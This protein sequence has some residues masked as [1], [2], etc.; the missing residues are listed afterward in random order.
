[1]LKKISQLI[2]VI[3]EKL[4][5]SF[6]FVAIVI[7]IT[8]ILFK[9]TIDTIISLLDKITIIEVLEQDNSNIKFN[10]AKKRLETYPSY[11]SIWANINIPSITV[12]A[13]IYHGDGL[14]I[15]KHG[16]G[17]YSGSYF[18]GEGGSIIFSA[19]NS[20]EHFK[21]LPNLQI[22][23]EIYVNTVY[24]KYTYEVTSGQ[25]IQATELSKY[26]VNDLKEELIMYTCYPV[27][28]FGYK[29]QRYVIFAKLV[30][31]EVE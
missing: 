19:H 12:E 18:P 23:D 20:E 3:V 29:T 1:M 17:H 14:D 13:P 31:D 7:T 9:D 27:D 16:I 22:G 4:A 28:S 15:I 10:Q 26:V 8:N 11:G 24:G 6:F 30:G 25:V 2:K 21:K 5:I